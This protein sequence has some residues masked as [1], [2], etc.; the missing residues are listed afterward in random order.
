MSIYSTYIFTS[1]YIESP[2]TTLAVSVHSPLHVSA[3]TASG[4]QALHKR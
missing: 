3:L 2:H 1:I 4:H